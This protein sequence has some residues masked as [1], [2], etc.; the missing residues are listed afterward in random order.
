M[1]A[2][3]STTADKKEE[4]KSKM[5]LVLRPSH[6][7]SPPTQDP[8]V[9]QRPGR[10]PVD[11]KQRITQRP[12]RRRHRLMMASPLS[13]CTA[14]V[15]FLQG[16]K[17]AGRPSTR[18]RY[19]GSTGS[20]SKAAMESVT[21]PEPS[22]PREWWKGA[23]TSRE[24][25]FGGRGQQSIKQRRGRKGARPRGLDDVFVALVVLGS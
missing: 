6:H 12:T 20:Q 7:A 14:G 1:Q 9:K 23:H 24:G 13:C 3:A 18:W 19:H 8:K 15:W 17:L 5:L 11:L 10:Q 4:E 16:L 2:E 22:L 21:G 25:R